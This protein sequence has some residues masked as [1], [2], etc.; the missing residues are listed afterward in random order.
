MTSPFGRGVSFLAFRVAHR[1]NRAN[2]AQ[3]PGSTL[4]TRRRRGWRAAAAT[5]GSAI[6]GAGADMGVSG[7]EGESSVIPKDGAGLPDPHF[8]SCEA[9][10]RGERLVELEKHLEMLGDRARGR[11][12]PGGARDHEIADRAGRVRGVA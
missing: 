4:P 3:Q 6:A 10:C 9:A 7:E 5:I 2:S 1:S 12:R 8:S 11:N